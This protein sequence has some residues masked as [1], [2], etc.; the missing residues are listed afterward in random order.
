MNKTVFIEKVAPVI[1]FLLGLSGLCWVVVDSLNKAEKW[2]VY[3][4]A[5]PEMLLYSVAKV[6]PNED[7]LHYLIVVR[8]PPFNRHGNPRL[9]E[10]IESVCYADRDTLQ[11]IIVRESG[12][13]EQFNL[14]YLQSGHTHTY[15]NLNTGEKGW[16]VSYVVEFDTHGL[17]ANETVFKNKHG[18]VIHLPYNATLENCK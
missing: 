2:E 17:N 6:P 12:V 18:A 14:P 16:M 13:R 5:D 15:F 4:S 8:S 9:Q 7:A 3:K 10:N 11:I 1:F